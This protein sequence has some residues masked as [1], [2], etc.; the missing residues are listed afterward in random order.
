MD[1]S[2]EMAGEVLK[3]F[4]VESEEIISKLNNN[5]MDLEKNPKNKD[6]ILLLFRDAHS[7]KGASRM[8]GFNNV[9][10]VAHKMEDVLGL[11]KEDKLLINSKIIDVLYK[12]VDCLATLIN[13]AITKGQETYTD[14]IAKQIELLENIENIDENL[15]P[16]GNEQ[17]DFNLE[18]FSKNLETINNLLAQTLCSLMNL[19]A[20]NDA[21]SIKNLLVSIEA[22][23]DIFIQTGPY[24][25]KKTF[26][27]LK[28]KL[29]FITKASN[30]LRSEEI[31]EFHKIFEDLI[32]KLISIFEIHNLPSVDYYD[33]AFNRLNQTQEDKTLNQQKKSEIFTEEEPEIE[34]QK[35]V[36]TF[37]ATI[38]QATPFSPDEIE[39]L[40]AEAQ[41]YSIEDYEELNDFSDIN[42]ASQTA[43]CSEESASFGELDET[44]KFAQTQNFSEAKVVSNY[45]LVCPTNLSEIQE[46][47]SVLWQNTSSLEEIRNTLSEFQNN[48]AKDEIKGI[49]E[50]L[51]KILDFAQTNEI[52]IDE[53]TASVLAESVEYCDNAMR[54]VGGLADK[55]LIMQ[56]LEIILQVLEFKTKDEEESALTAAKPKKSADF[57]EIFDSG[58]IKTLR[59]DSEK[60]DALVSQVNE[61]T[62]TK[63]KTRKY[64]YELNEVNNELEECQ[65]NAT[66]ALTYLKNFD[67]KVFQAEAIDNS[68][69]SFI[70]QFLTTFSESTRK[71]QEIVLS[72]SNIQ[73]TFQEDDTKIN[74]ALDNLE[75][76]VKNIRVLPLA[77]VFHLFGRMVRD[78]AQENN[79][80]I[81]LEILGS[82]TTTDKKI[83]EEIKTP[84]I[85]IIRNA[86]DHGIETPEER[87]AAGKNPTGKI[88]LSAKQVNNKVI[89][90]IK[91]DGRGINIAKIKEKA[92]HKGFLTEEE[93][94]SMDDDQITNLIFA[95]GFSTGDEITNLSG[96]GIGL[97][98]VQTK[99]EQ[100]NGRVR[101]LSE[102]NRGCC[103]QIELP[104]AMSL[105]KSFLVKSANQLFAVPMEVIKTVIRKRQDEIMRTNNSESIILDGE[106]ISLYNLA[107]VLNLSGSREANSIL[108]ILIIESND[109][110]IA[111]AVDKLIGDQEILHKK[112]S[113]PFYKLKNI[114]GIT[115]LDSGEICFILNISDILNNAN[116]AKTHLIPTKSAPKMQ[117]SD[118]KILLVDDSIT[119][120]TLEKNILARS[121]YML[122]T[123][124]NPITAFEKLKSESFDLIISDVEM[125]EMDGFTFLEKLKT[126]EMYAEIPV[127]MMSSLSYDE[128]Y[129]KAIRMG[130]KTFLNKNNFKQD[131]FLEAVKAALLSSQTSNYN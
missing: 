4:Q 23:A 13:K 110:I 24:D 77:M 78:I 74:V 123:A 29:E 49:F 26:E 131:E 48:C 17:L 11:A 96:R 118:Y 76:M 41:E 113:A 9:Q 15:P 75:S 43:D 90:E 88:T 51:I 120:I 20:T 98:V 71:V 36:E 69:A 33:L 52:I 12:T 64:L 65:K 21:S 127:I 7:L 115:T 67:K 105:M 119:T 40:E 111:L 5:L 99:I 22:L 112:L 18:L 10:A 108:T 61:L 129:A 45:N 95:P 3:I 42:E 121:G 27:D 16:Q 104:T 62:V 106:K 80:K 128:N 46:K 31:A 8:V 70:K 1:F 32:D 92:L 116:V 84:L 57:T 39:K 50:T 94:E 114:S 30:C 93:L 63:I 56:R 89:I 102:M 60:L 47:V 25:I 73:R 97:D 122:E 79:K 14:E 58:E 53:E 38:P 35:Q 81:D 109:Q 126:D 125:P 59:V 91:D 54:N 34:A 28:F 124:E 19:E 130:A 103:V 117:N 101:V 85:H 83:I 44:D 55:D 68:H 107:N 6:A 82:E 86:I 2:D 72:I 100:L 87:A 66:K 37:E